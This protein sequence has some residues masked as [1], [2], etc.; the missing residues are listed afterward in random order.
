M[1]F[2]TTVEPRGMAEAIRWFRDRFPVTEELL[3]VLG[4][5]AGKR[6]WTIAEVAQLDLVNEAHKAID[7]G[8]TEGW[9]RKRLGKRLREIFTDFSE[10][11][12]ET[13]ARTNVQRAYMAGRWEQMSDPNI[14]GVFPFRKIDAILDGRTSDICV[15]YDGKTL[16][17]DDPWWL[18]HW[19]PYHF[20]CRTQVRTCTEDEYESVPHEKRV[21]DS[22][23]RPPNGFGPAPVVD[24]PYQPDLSKYPMRLAGIFD[25]K[26][27]ES[28]E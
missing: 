9:D 19:P 17:H 3:A 18:T 8:I 22:Q 5:Y 10:A 25:Q 23:F 27:R 20:S 13:I 24:T 16:Q 4:S 6:A 2:T 26:R 14:T 15:D 11:R 1:K 21:A 28:S 7:I 12:C